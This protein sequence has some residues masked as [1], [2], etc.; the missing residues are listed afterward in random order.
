[1]DACV[2]EAGFGVAS[3]TSIKLDDLVVTTGAVAVISVVSWVKGS[4]HR[5]KS[6]IILSFNKH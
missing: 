2:T 5:G 6:A 3:E 1:M 4:L